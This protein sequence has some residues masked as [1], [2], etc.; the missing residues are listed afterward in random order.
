MVKILDF[1]K[2][3]L[4]ISNTFLLINSTKYIYIFIKI[5][6]FF[7][8]IILAEVAIIEFIIENLK[9]DKKDAF[10]AVIYR[11]QFNLLNSNIK[12]II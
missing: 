7:W 11:V 8:D 4:T 1:K 12:N 3:Y 2:V 9:V 6:L 10:K 5:L